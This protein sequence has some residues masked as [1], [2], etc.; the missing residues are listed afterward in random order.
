MFSG[1]TPYEGGNRLWVLDLQR[2]THTAVSPLDDRILWGTWSPDGQQVVYE[3]L[4][5]GRGT[6]HMIRPDGSGAAQ[7]IAEARP[8][9]QSPGSWASTGQL[10]FVESNSATGTD[11]RVLDMSASNRTDSIAVQTSGSDSFPVFSPDGKWLAY[12]SDTS[13]RWD[14]YV[15]P[16]P[17]SGPRVLVS[18]GGGIA[19]TWRGDGREIYYYGS[20]NGVLRM[21]A[22]PVVVNG[23]TLS[24]GTPRELFRLEGRYGTT[25]PLRGYD[26]TSDGKRFLFF[27]SGDPPVLP[28]PQLVLV[29]HWSRELARKT[30]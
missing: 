11:I 4:D 26:V 27:R 28:P 9:F 5:A 1:A 24:T 6:L 3:K 8:V 29:E 2:G 21:Y 25:A 20:G 23:A 18:T 10:A 15:Q 16:Y 19:P 17:G 12:A 7:P 22:V 13:G 14:V 30:R